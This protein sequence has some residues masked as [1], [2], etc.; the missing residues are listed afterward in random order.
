MF[1][2]K[3]VPFDRNLGKEA[4]TGAFHY[5]L[6]NILDFLELDWRN[7]ALHFDGKQINIGGVTLE[8]GSSIVDPVYF[9]DIPERARTDTYNITPTKIGVT[10]EGLGDNL[11]YDCKN[12]REI[13]DRVS[14]LYDG[15]CNYIKDDA[16]TLDS[17]VCY[18]IEHYKEYK[19]KFVA[20]DF[21][22]L[23]N[24][25]MFREY[26]SAFSNKPSTYWVQINSLTYSIGP[27]EVCV[28]DEN[29]QTN[30]KYSGDAKLLYTNIQRLYSDIIINN[31]KKRN[32]Q[33]IWRP[34]FL[35]CLLSTSVGTALGIC[36]QR[37]FDKQPAPHKK[38]VNIQPTDTTNVLHIPKGMIR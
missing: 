32:W 27:S 23:G 34:L 29:T 16:N 35:S 25:F 18:L 5:N 13:Y 9:M 7:Y 22:F 4:S 36:L 21:I 10:G 28:R 26:G 19:L 37:H 12:P 33:I 6:Q 17:V 24:N 3:N 1:K 20:N 15:I 8:P 11:I 14:K 30:T 2:K 31:T 38:E